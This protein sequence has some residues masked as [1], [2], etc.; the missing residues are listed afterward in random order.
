MHLSDY[1]LLAF[2]LDD[3][4][5]L[6]DLYDECGYHPQAAIVRCIWPMPIFRTMHLVIGGITYYIGV[7]ERSSVRGQIAVTV[8]CGA[9]E[10]YSRIGYY[11]HLLTRVPAE[12]FG[13]QFVWGDLYNKYRQ[14]FGPMQPDTNIDPYMQGVLQQCLEYTAVEVPKR[15]AETLTQN[16]FHPVESEMV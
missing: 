1:D 16:K 10:V 12:Y 14:R 9:S 3:Y 11:T 4:G 8:H 6:A 7:Y 2:K 5:Q 13:W 15:M